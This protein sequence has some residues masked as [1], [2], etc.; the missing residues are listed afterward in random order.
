MVG[1]VVDLILD[2]VVGGAVVVAGV[3][4]VVSDLVVVP[5]SIHILN[6]QDRCY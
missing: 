3:G 1:F 2:F 5:K 6:F 4:A